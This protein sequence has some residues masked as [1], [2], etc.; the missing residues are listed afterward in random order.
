MSIGDSFG[1]RQSEGNLRLMENNNEDFLDD[2]VRYSGCWVQPGTQDY[3]RTNPTWQRDT[4]A[5]LGNRVFSSRRRAQGSL[6]RGKGRDNLR[7]RE[8]AQQQNKTVKRET[9]DFR[10]HVEDD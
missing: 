3:A 2:L 4:K 6:A 10:A 1:V 7:A 8:G 5:D 9:A